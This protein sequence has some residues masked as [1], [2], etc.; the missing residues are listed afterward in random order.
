[1]PDNRWQRV[2]EILGAARER[3]VEARQ[4]FLKEACGSDESL[5]REVES[6]LAAEGEAAHFLSEPAHLRPAARL[7]TGT[8]LGPHEIEAF[9]GAGG[10]G[11]VYKAR[12]TRLDRTVAIKMLPGNFA[13]D[14]ERARRFER[15]ARTISKLNHPHICALYD[16]GQYDGARFLVM[17]Y[18]EGENLAER[19]SKGALPLEEALRYGRQIAEALEEAHQQGIVHRDLKPANVMLTKKGAKLLDFGI[20]KL[21]AG[22]VSEEAPTATA[23][24]LTGEGVIVGTPQYMAPEQLEGK[25]VDARTDVFAFGVV[26]YEMVTGRKAFEAPSRAG[27]IVAI[28]ERE[29]PSLSRFQPP[30]PQWLEALVQR[31]L[32][33]RPADR[34]QSCADLL[35][36]L[37]AGLG[38]RAP[39]IPIPAL[40]SR[41]RRTLWMGGAAAALC[42]AAA[43]AWWLARSWGGLSRVPA[44][45]LTFSQLTD[46]PG[47]ELY[48]TLSPAGESLAYAARS[49]GN[50]DI[51]FQRVGGKN[52]IN[53]TPDS[54]ADDTQPAFSPDGQHIAFRSERSGGGIFLMGATGESVKRLTD[55][56]YNPSWSPD[57]KQIVCATTRFAR[58]EIRYM[59]TSQLFAVEV[60]TGAKRLLTTTVPDAVQP[61]WSPHGL[62]IAFWGYPAGWR[63]IWTIPADGGEPVRVTND[64]HVDWNP[65]WSADGRFIYFSSDRGGSMNLWR[66]PIDE[67]SGK[68]LGPV[69]P[70]TTPSPDSGYISISRDGRRTAYVQQVR[71]LNLAR[72]GFDPIR[73]T[74]VGGP[75]PVTR[76]LRNLSGPQVSPD[77]QWVSFSRQGT[78]EDVFV[79]RTDGTGLRQLTDDP[80]RDRGA[81]WSPDGKRLGFFSSRSGRDEIWSMNTDGSDL[82]QLTDFGCSNPPHWS[83]DGRRFV[84]HRMPGLTTPVVV[85][86]DGANSSA[87]QPLPPWNEHPGRFQ[88]WDWSPDGRSL[89][90]HILTPGGPSGVVVYRFETRQYQRLTEFGQSPRW[91]SD[92][93]RLLFQHEG[94]IYRVDAHT[95]EI[96]RVFSAAPLEVDDFFGLSRDNRLIVFGLVDAQADVWLIEAK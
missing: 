67:R 7:Q 12:D 1:V 66:I 89:A 36:H 27:L 29:P 34:W 85:A 46:Q 16:V 65:V 80:P 37:Q 2:K 57:G 28:L 52:P 20:A 76:G 30:S 35:V 49:A 78:Q 87:P 8:R 81:R 54:P 14:P 3:P 60:A 15:E 73:E 4:S 42:L 56:G 64:V 88:V 33:K 96:R 22:A 44:P 51:Y 38:G 62:R 90:G 53:L 50:W 93:R 18:L 24:D 74:V 94:E 72:I 92:S 55:F 21:R 95:K 45:Q 23:S 6:L 84:C 32:A 17:E 47:S 75:V 9:L 79:I 10:M 63:D 91:L 40:G 70:I 77:G 11:E 82:R 86:A 26:L 13:A 58:P 83:P 41:R 5:R 39:A 59:N 19:L 68:V 43:A 69:E 61:H 71:T 31:C 48:P 25:P